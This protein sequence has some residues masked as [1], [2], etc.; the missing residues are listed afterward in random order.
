MGDEACLLQ[1]EDC[2]W[3]YSAAFERALGCGLSVESGGQR[4]TGTSKESCGSS[5]RL[6]MTPIKPDPSP[7]YSVLHG[8][9]ILTLSQISP[10]GLLAW[11]S[12]T[13]DKLRHVYSC[14]FSNTALRVTT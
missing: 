7:I 14:P 1:R 11:V 5:D 6:V 3:W 2:V 4:G 8:R 9:S 10:L 12:R 13:S